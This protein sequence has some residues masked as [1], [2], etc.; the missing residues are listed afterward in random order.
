MAYKLVHTVHAGYIL[1]LNALQLKNLVQSM[2]HL[3]AMKF[4]FN[5]PFY[6]GK[7]FRQLSTVVNYH[8]FQSQEHHHQMEDTF[9]NFLLLYN[10]WQGTKLT[11]A[12]ISSSKDCNLWMKEPMLKNLLTNKEYKHLIKL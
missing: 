8:Q 4:S 12:M 3:K 6:R 2:N 1:F 9:Q 10:V 11:L 7:L 5:F